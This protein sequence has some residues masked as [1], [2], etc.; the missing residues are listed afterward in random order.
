MQRTLLSRV[1]IPLL[2]PSDS[3]TAHYRAP[4]YHLATLL[5]DHFEKLEKVVCCNASPDLHAKH[6]PTSSSFHD[7]PTV[8]RHA[9]RLRPVCLPIRQ[10][11]QQRE[12]ASRPIGT[13]PPW[14]TQRSSQVLGVAD[15]A[16]AHHW[17]SIVSSPAN[18]GAP[19]C[20]PVTSKTTI[21]F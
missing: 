12:W 13:V 10:I 4:R 5:A 9:Q 8:T 3:E 16:K 6:P 14:P 20:E 15:R 19:R 18:R 11:L 7:S 1:R 21:Y 2:G 17:L